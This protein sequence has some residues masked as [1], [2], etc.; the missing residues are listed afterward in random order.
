MLDH[1]G[2]GFVNSRDGE[3]R[4]DFGFAVTY[5]VAGYTVLLAEIT[6]AG[7][8]HR[9][10]FQPTGG[11][12]EIDLGRDRGL[13]RGH[14]CGHGQAG[15]ADGLQTYYCGGER[16]L[17][18][19]A[20]FAPVDEWHEHQGKNRESGQHDAAEYLE[21][22]TEKLQS[23]EEKQEVP[24]RPRDVRGV[25]RIGQLFERHAHRH[26]HHEQRDERDEDGDGV[27]KSLLGEEFFWRLKFIAG[28]RRHAVLAH[29]VD[30]QHDQQSS[31]R[32]QQQD[33]HSVETREGY[34]ADV[35]LAS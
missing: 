5:G 34:D 8:L 17:G 30:V 15:P 16:P 24:F 14:D 32:R 10:K 6:D 3:I 35:A 1:P 11:L 20:H 33:V 31:G 9:R 26:G 4:A 22:T 28:Y 18:Y 2:S 21:R 19:F 27:A 7:H 12:R 25:R 29:Q 23:L 13:G